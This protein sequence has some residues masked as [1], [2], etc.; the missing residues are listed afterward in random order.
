MDRVAISVTFRSDHSGE[1]TVC[2]MSTDP[3]PE[4]FPEI[5]HEF[6]ESVTE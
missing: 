5:D 6:T 1:F 3:D 4:K 2:R